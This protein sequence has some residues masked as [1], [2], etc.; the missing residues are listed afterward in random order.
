MDIDTIPR[1]KTF[2]VF[3][4]GEVRVRRINEMDVQF[5]TIKVIVYV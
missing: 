2:F 4:V 5:C 3:T 1:D